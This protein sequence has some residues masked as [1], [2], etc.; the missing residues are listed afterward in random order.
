MYRANVEGTMSVLRAAEAAGA[1]RIVHTSTVGTLG[2]PADGTPGN[3]ETP[4]RLDDMIGHYKRSKFLAEAAAR[5]YAKER[6]LHLVVV[7]PSTPVGERDVKPTPTGRMIV[8]FVAGRMPAYVDTGLNLVDVRDVAEGHILAA[9]RGASGRGYILGNAN[10]TL[11]EIL[12]ELSAV[13]GIPA[14]AMRMP[15][16]CAFAFAFVDTFWTGV[17]RGHEPRA[18]LEAVRMARKLMFFDSFR[19]VCELDMPQSPV[20]AALQRA[21][22]WFLGHGYCEPRRAWTGART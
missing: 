20:R 14:P 3:E 21:V 8:D 5:A 17:L 2:I 6:G 10:L 13:T 16:W 4:V 7:Y 1:A 15:Y 9:E 18:S 12:V 22:E 19:A 11:R